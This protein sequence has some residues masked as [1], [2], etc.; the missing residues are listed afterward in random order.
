[1]ISNKTNAANLIGNTTIA[2]SGGG[3]VLLW[4]GDN[5][6]GIGALA[7]L[8]GLIG[9]FIFKT[10]S[11]YELKRHHKELESIRRSER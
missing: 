10:L 7:V 11:I 8:L 5:A 3:G 1:M 4:L 2:A 6:T 9:G